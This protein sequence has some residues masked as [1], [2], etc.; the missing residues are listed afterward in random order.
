[1][2]LLQGLHMQSDLSSLAPYPI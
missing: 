1:L 2:L